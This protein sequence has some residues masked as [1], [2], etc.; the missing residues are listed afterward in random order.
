M[1]LLKRFVASRSFQKALGVTA[2]EYL[3]FVWKTN[4]LTIEPAEIYER[5]EADLPV[6]MAVWHGQHFLLPFAKRDEHHRAKVLISR[7]RDGEINAIAAERLGIGTIRGSGAHGGDFARKGGVTAFREILQALE[8]N[9]SV[10]L[11]ADVPK[12]SRVAGLGIVMLA[13]ASGRPILPVAIANSRRIEFK[14]WDRTTLGLPFGRCG[15]VAGELIRVPKADADELET[16]RK[17]VE[18]GLNRA[19]RRAYEIAEQRARETRRA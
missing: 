11:T 4:R 15:A 5:I 13:S 7:H 12:V 2:A 9:Y 14:S 6:I 10:A 19:E 8:E 3:R 1:S 16:Y 17:Q 18:D